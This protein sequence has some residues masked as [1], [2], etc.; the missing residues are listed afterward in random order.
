MA[1]EKQRNAKEGV[2]LA[3]IVAGAA[4]QSVGTGAAAVAP[5][6]AS[7]ASSPAYPVGGV[8]GQGE[9]QRRQ[10]AKDDG[11]GPP[12]SIRLDVVG[13]NLV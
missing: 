13:G 12:L 1:Q 7:P 4:P 6:S 10:T 8:V 3:S 5:A 11:L 2:P 9:A